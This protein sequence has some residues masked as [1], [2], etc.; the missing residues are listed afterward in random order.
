ML[1]SW[2]KRRLSTMCNKGGKANGLV[3]DYPALSTFITFT[4][5]ADLA[6]PRFF[7]GQKTAGTTRLHNTYVDARGH[8]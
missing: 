7:A 8:L 2:K 3:L 1:K 6:N 5:T 4:K